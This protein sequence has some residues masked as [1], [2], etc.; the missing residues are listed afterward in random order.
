MHE[1]CHLYD[2]EP[3]NS[4]DYY[5]NSNGSNNWNHLS[6]CRCQ[7]SPEIFCP[8]CSTSGY[9]CSGHCGCE[10]CQ[11]LYSDYS[12]YIYPALGSYNARANSRG[13]NALNCVENE[14]NAKYLSTGN[15]LHST[16][17]KR[18]ILYLNRYNKENYSSYD[19]ITSEISS[20]TTPEMNISPRSGRVSF[21]VPKCSINDDR[22]NNTST[23]LA[24]DSFHSCLACN[25]CQIET[26]FDNK[27]RMSSKSTINHS[28]NQTINEA[29][30]GT[31][32]TPLSAKQQRRKVNSGYFEFVSPTR[33]Q[34]ASTFPNRALSASKRETSS[35]GVDILKKPIH[36][37]YFEVKERGYDSDHERISLLEL[38]KVPTKMSKQIDT[39][40]L[41]ESTMIDKSL[42]ANFGRAA[43][44]T[45]NKSLLANINVKNYRT[46]TQSDIAKIVNKL[47]QN[48]VLQKRGI[49]ISQMQS[50]S[51]KS[52]T[53][54][55]KNASSKQ[56]LAKVR[57][58]THDTKKKVKTVRSLSEGSVHDRKESTQK[59]QQKVT[60]YKNSLNAALDK[61]ETQI[62]KK[63]KTVLTSY[64][65]TPTKK[66]L[67]TLYNSN[68]DNTR[69]TH[70]PNT[71]PK[72]DKNST[73]TNPSRCM[74]TLEDIIDSEEVEIDTSDFD[75][76]SS[77]S[78]ISLP[79]QNGCNY[80]SDVS[81]HNTEHINSTYASPECY[82]ITNYQ[83]HP[84]ERDV[85]KNAGEVTFVTQAILPQHNR[86]GYSEKYR[87][88][89][90]SC[91][92]ASNT[93]SNPSPPR[94]YNSSIGNSDSVATGERCTSNPPESLGRYHQHTSR[95]KSTD[96]ARPKEVASKTH[97]ALESDMREEDALHTTR[98]SDASESK[99][100]GTP[101]IRPVL[102]RQRKLVPRQYTSSLRDVS[103]KQHT[104]HISERYKTG[105]V[106]IT[107]RSHNNPEPSE[108]RRRSNKSRST[109][110]GKYKY[111]RVT[112]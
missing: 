109:K 62:T 59:S 14:N 67:V 104:A 110:S 66:P 18:N 96:T 8:S 58:S 72:H 78:Q 26:V 27:D 86:S 46:L 48:Q 51:S 35:F 30:S 73:G 9:Y 22:S 15:R 82:E 102:R 94:K 19:S 55:K 1:F 2:E 87:D 43:V 103:Q 64:M 90:T 33:N 89:S 98:D 45:S 75:G 111:T 74:I 107:N 57:S 61:L 112:E 92:G 40:H 71:E 6:N 101:T 105:E 21:N 42:S 12:E 56:S 17:R 97:N 91:C 13:L 25:S 99:R 76:R 50:N 39:T 10:E 100:P 83:N 37:G 79:A 32:R 23:S 11:D 20:T 4:Y 88:Y 84:S 93:Y 53:N 5:Q 63:I 36:Y 47:M 41:K 44:K 106:S 24:K 34:T 95:D 7:Y 29:L 85:V 38:D 54:F 70:L 60:S 49:K 16:H 31:Y 3:I 68:T 80:N 69:R 65:D 52:L 77:V 108:E 28:S 81:S